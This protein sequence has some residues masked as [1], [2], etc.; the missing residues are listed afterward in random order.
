[1]K[2]LLAT[3]FI[4]V[5]LFASPAVASGKILTLELRG[6]TFEIVTP[7]L[8]NLLIPIRIEIDGCELLGDTVAGGFGR[9]LGFV[10]VGVC[11]D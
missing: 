1:M 7:S 3:L 10:G 8:S 2:A 6:I 4:S 9:V 5:F 11:T